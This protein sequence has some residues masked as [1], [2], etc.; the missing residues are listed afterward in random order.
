MDIF[1]EA[2]RNPLVRFNLGNGDVTVC[3]LWQ[4]NV[5]KLDQLHSHLSAQLSVTKAVSLLRPKTASSDLLELKLEVV[6]N[7][8]ET[9][10][11][12]REERANKAK[13][14]AQ[15]GLI[16]ER[17]ASLEVETLEG[18]SKEELL[19]Q[20]VALEGVVPSGGI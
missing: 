19:A 15:A 8:V 16:R 4:Y 6:K 18:L 2:T 12:E 17:L 10:L 11:A 5:D 20:L 14:S 7:V 3:D 1:K 13:A 9:K